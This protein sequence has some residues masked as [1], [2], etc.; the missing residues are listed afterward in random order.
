M[1]ETAEVGIEVD[2]ETYKKEAE[3]LRTALLAAQMR[4]AEAP[5]SVLVV[6]GGVEG[7]GKTELVNLM[8]EWMDAR[9]IEVSAFGAA[10][11]EERERPPL[12]RYWRALPPTSK[13][14]VF[15]GSWYSQPIVDRV[16]KR[17]DQAALDQALER[18]VKLEAMLG[19]ENVLVLKFWM[20]LSKKAQRKRLKALE[21]DP[22]TRWRV[23]DQDWEF[24]KLYNRFRKV[25]E[26]ALMKTSVGGAPWHVIEA[27]DARYRS[28]AFAGILLKALEARLAKA[29]PPRPPKPELPKPPRVNIISRLDLG[30]TMD[31]KKFKKSLLKHQSRL[32]LLTRRL[33]DEKRSMILV[34]EG[35]DAAGKGGAIRR[36][37][38]AMDARNFQVISVAAPTEEERAHPYQW[39]FWRRLPRQGRVTIYDRSWYG[40]VLVERLEGFCAPEDWQRAYG[41]I[42][43]FEEELTDF[44]TVIVK[45]WLATSPEEQLRRFKDRQKTAYKQYKITEEDWRNRDK[46]D[47]YVAA[48]CDMI[49]QTSTPAAP[50]VLV[51]ANDKP[52]ARIKVLEA[53]CRAL[54][55][56]LKRRP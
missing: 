49:E 27:A 46:W 25:S 42:N 16:F 10:T 21:S 38:Q 22:D 47:G 6:I 36:L 15:L 29:A 20:H 1:F 26:H 17:I 12:W 40:R 14:G 37:T 39:R 8:L 43:G 19:E 11:D 50:W 45:F 9:G 5:F 55:K 41:E 24:F 3:R 54:E 34:F 52:W 53:T 18:I 51:E 23:S 4:L 30:R 56:G 28:L 48:A 32:A 33:Y 13:L 35:P 7:A 44:G 31:E 2:K